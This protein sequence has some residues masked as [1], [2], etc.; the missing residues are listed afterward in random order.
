MTGA[1]DDTICGIA[2][3]LGEGGVGI[4]RLS[5]SHSIEI[6]GV[7]AKLRSGLPLASTRNHTLYLADVTLP[8]YGSDSPA[9]ASKQE[10]VGDEALIVVMRGPRS[11]TG[12]DVV[13]FHCHGG[14]LILHTVCGAIIAAGGRL[15]EPGEFTKRAFLNGRLDLAQAEAVLDTIR[16]KTAGSLRVAQAQRRGVLSREIEGIRGDLVTALAHVEAALD[17]SEEDIAFVGRAELV[18]L[19]VAMSGRLA[20]LLETARD[21]RILREG[22]TVAIVG[23]PNVGKSSLLNA[24][25]STD[26]A[27]VTAIP[28]TTRDVLDEWLNIQGVPIRILDTAGIR[29]THDPVEQEGIERSHRAVEDADAVLAVF[30]GSLPLEESDRSVLKSL[31]SKRS[32]IVVNKSDLSSQLDMTE[33]QVP[34]GEQRPVVRLSAQTG[35]GLPQLRDH[36]RS[37]ILREGFEPNEGLYV[38]NLRHITSLRSAQEGLTHALAAIDD[39]LSG[40]FVAADL[41][42]A[43]DALGEITGA[44]STDDILNRI[45][46]EFCIGK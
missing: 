4:V 10:V 42:M 12:E 7:L 22:A 46:S 8:V 34:G 38:T 32:V 23:R 39:Q 9:T 30:D 24:L 16:A 21:G 29:E 35:A 33:L 45:F 43:A 41:R 40:E 36:I 15:A 6:A 28:G 18:A 20:R 13:E 1:L 44:I 26:R 31:Q 37:S 14:T 27:I 5:G 19:L 3:P 17:F 11:F 25:T 2:T